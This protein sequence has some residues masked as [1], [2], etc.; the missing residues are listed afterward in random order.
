MRRSPALTD[1][2][3]WVT[4]LGVSA[5]RPRAKQHLYSAGPAA[6]PA[7]RRGLRHPKPI[8]RRQCVNL[9]DH[10]MDDASVGDLVSALDD[11]EPSVVVRA[12]HSLACDRCK[13]NEC[14]PGEDLWVPRALG[15]VG[16]PNPD[17]RAGAIDALG[18]VARRRPEVVAV[19]AEAAENDPHKGLR[20]MARRFVPTQRHTE[21]QVASG[22]SF[23]RASAGQR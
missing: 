19:L 9:L 15:L 13:E 5:Q 17:L 7:L 20:G 23:R 16:D 6:V 22:A 10:F 18:K 8:V 2:D 4:Q 11:P 1:F 12:L 14:R 21:G 3:G